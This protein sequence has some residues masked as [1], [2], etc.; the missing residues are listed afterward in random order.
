M[1]SN[2]NRNLV[3]MDSVGTSNQERKMAHFKNNI[4]TT[5]QSAKQRQNKF[6]ISERLKRTMQ[7]LEEPKYGTRL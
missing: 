2:T 3:Q 1:D 6:Q 5:G 4:G 7:L